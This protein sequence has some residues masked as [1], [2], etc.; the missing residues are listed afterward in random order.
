M[1]NRKRI[2]I[3]AV[4]LA[5]AVSLAIG[6]FVGRPL[7][8]FI[9]EPEL[10]RAWVDSHGWKARFA[11]VGMLVFQIII[12]FIPGE[13]FEL[14]AGYA[15]GAF[16]GTILCLAGS[17]LGSIL[18]FLLVRRFGMRIVGVFFSEEKIA[19]LRFLKTTQRREML[20]LLVYVL[21]GTPKDILSYYAGLTDMPFAMWLLISFLGRIPSVV[22]ST[23]GGDALGSQRYVG[24]IFA[25]AVTLVISI[26]GILLYNAIVSRHSRDRRLAEGP[27]EQPRLVE[28]SNHTKPDGAA[29]G[30]DDGQTDGP[31]SGPGEGPCG[32]SNPGSSEGAAV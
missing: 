30:M 31:G 19:K 24:A 23:I 15:F 22:T 4:V 16:E 10:F 11:F 6:W 5:L 13:P 25:F 9:S 27:S 26:G 3:G 7:V 14:A 28:K 20:F 1:E 21:P 12:A 32:G 8:K 18:V 2:A 17:A 29:H